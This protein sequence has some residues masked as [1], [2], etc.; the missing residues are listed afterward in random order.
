MVKKLLFLSMAFLLMLGFSSSFVTSSAEASQTTEK[1]KYKE[2]L[3][4]LTKEEINAYFQKIDKEY[5]IGEE[6]SL[7]DQAFVEMY[8]TPVIPG[9]MTTFA[10]KYISDSGSDNGVTVKVSGYIE[11]DIQ[12]II[13][14]SFGARDL[15]TSTTAGSSKVTSVRTEV[16]HTA[17]GLVGSGG[18]GKVYSGSIYTTGK[19][20]TLNETKRYSAI[21]A[22]AST[23][24]TVTVKH[25]GGTFTINPD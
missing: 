10:Q 20:T 23:W 1:E 4:D 19:N 12:N 5:D 14:Q 25:S 24:C 21:V 16:H 3:A 17:Y 7:K 15:K 2:E 8:A 13:N 11:D 9:G 6:F 18:I 22:Y